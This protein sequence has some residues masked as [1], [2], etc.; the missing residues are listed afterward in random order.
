LPELEEILSEA[1]RRIDAGEFV[2]SPGE[3]ACAGCP[4]LDL[5]CAGPRLRDVP[6][7]P[8]EATAAV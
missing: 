4:A 1:I 8:H 6:F 7:V 2:P 3:F 5:V